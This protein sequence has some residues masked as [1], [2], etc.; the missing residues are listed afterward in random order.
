MNKAL[1]NLAAELAKMKAERDADDEGGPRRD[2]RKL[3]NAGDTMVG[4][5]MP[6]VGQRPWATFSLGGG[7]VCQLRWE[8]A[9]VTNSATQHRDQ[10]QHRACILTSC[11]VRC[12]PLAPATTRPIPST[13]WRH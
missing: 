3:E 1:A 7:I 11:P 12:S 2:Q 6:C 4:T 9:Q 10:H 8:P 13:P 5:V